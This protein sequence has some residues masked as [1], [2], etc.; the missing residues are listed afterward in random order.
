MS[1][2]TKNNKQKVELNSNPVSCLESLIK[3]HRTGVTA[4]CERGKALLLFMTVAPGAH[5]EAYRQRTIP[6]S[7][8]NLVQSQVLC[9]LK[10]CRHLITLTLVTLVREKSGM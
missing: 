2:V 5:S 6:F 4:S 9:F 1:E 8:Y 10:T 3:Q 7:R